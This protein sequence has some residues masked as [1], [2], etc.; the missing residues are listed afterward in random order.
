MTTATPGSEA[1]TREAVMSTSGAGKDPGSSLFTG[2]STL[3]RL[4]LRR[5]RIQLAV[6][7]AAAV[8]LVVVSAVSIDG[9]YP[10]QADLDGY[11]ALVEDNPVVVIQA[12]PGYGLDSSPS[13]GA[14][15]MNELSLWTL[16]LVSI[17]SVFLVTR[18]TRAEE[19]TER[20]ELLRSSIVGRRAAGAATVTGAFV[21]NVA[22]ATLV[23]GGLVA[24][25]Y[26]LTGSAAFASA[27]VCTGLAFA[28]VTLV[29]AQVASTGRSST[30]LAM[31]VLAVSF[32]LR[33][34]GDVTGNGLSWFSPLGW[35]QGIRAFADERWWVLLLPLAF[36]AILVS[37]ASTLSEHRD[38]GAGML[39]DRTGRASA[40]RWLAT[41]LALS[42][43]LQRG[44]I[45]GWALGLLLFGTFYGA[46]ADEIDQMIA[47]NPE[48]ADFIALTSGSLTE[49]FLA[50]AAT[51]LALLVAGFVTSAV[52]RPNSEES[53]GR[54]EALL[55]T[56]TSRARWAGSHVLVA[57]PAMV[58]VLALG[59][60]GLGLGAAVSTGDSD[61]FARMVG[62]LVAYAPASA[63]VAS[64]AFAL[65]GLAP[66][67][68]ML[69][70]V[71]LVYVAVVG[72]FAQMLD[73]PQWAR[74]ISPFEH[75][76][77]L[78]AEGFD[79]A[80]LLVL[81]VVAAA[82]FVV[83]FVGFRRRDLA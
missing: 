56:P 46:V 72:L 36:A 9:L 2:W 15:L 22:V 5:D 31:V 70:W 58:F 16:I 24:L 38:F 48:L 33:A 39:P 79:A 25:G 32:V 53:N 52:L 12:G 8:A 59:G 49:A 75:V 76:P 44:S 67:L 4:L 63:V 45:V 35:G 51:I 42:A 18:H 40:T 13:T 1:A 62:A 10:T 77:G 29:C 30:G 57:L 26:D 68:A 6:W 73:L 37:V 74:N 71:P 14:V 3:L 20:A 43:R 50:S 23:L 54:V 80:P 28:A 19:E 41:P 82:V 65:W 17:M 27:L 47:D 64:V 60:A 66:R 21:A 69:G 81:S 61:L 7:V 55:A 78:P 11:G 34:V 83:G